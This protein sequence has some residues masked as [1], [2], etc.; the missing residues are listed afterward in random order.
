MTH[1]KLPGLSLTR[2]RFLAGSAALGG[3]MMLPGLMN[4]AWA[5]GSDAPEKKEIRV[6][7]IPLTDC[8]SVVMASVKQFDQKYGIK[9]IPS[10]E[11]SW[12]AVRD[13]LL[14]G[15]LDAA[16]VLYGMV[17]G[18]QLGV[19]GP[20]QDMAVLMTLNNNGQAITLSNQ[21]KQ[22]GVTDA[23][24]LK[25]TV[26]ASAKGTYTFAQTFPTGTHAMWLYYWLANAGIH[27][28]DDVR[29]VVVPPPQMVMNMKIGNM[30]G[31]C[32]GEPWNQRAIAED[33]GFT[34]VTSQEIW[35]DHPEKVLGTTGNW[36]AAN[37]NSARALTAAVLDAARW[38][39]SSDANR[40]ET[41]QVVAGRAYINTKPEIIT[42]RMLGQYQNGLGKSW[43]DAHA[44]RFFHDG[45]VSYPYL[46]D[47]MWFLTQHRR[48]GLLNADPDYLA[49][50]KKINRT[51]IYKQAASAVGG[52]NLPTGDMRTSTL[53]DGKRWDG[54]NPAEYANSFS[55]KR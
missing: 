37:P 54:S 7:F 25:K 26:D 39:D 47:G 9:I 2:R 40:Q 8:A 12:A 50:A 28:F 21:L 19:A 22:A 5:A 29:N 51:E 42:G 1:T 20:Q 3:S 17:Y 38:I 11:A 33:I 41:A 31:F 53:L 18:L 36:V 30:S 24:S 35:P 13:K 14:S 6:G 44:M 45:E 52:V 49:V 16:H 46:S 34:A 10:K 23:A 27:P 43:Q 48:W 4:T 55:L 15:E 32:V